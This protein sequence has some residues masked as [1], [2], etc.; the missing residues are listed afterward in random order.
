MAGTAYLDDQ[1]SDQWSEAYESVPVLAKEYPTREKFLQAAPDFAY[2][3][4][5][6]A[7]ES[8]A[9]GTRSEL[10]SDGITSFVSPFGCPD[11]KD[12][13]EATFEAAWD[14]V[15]DVAAI[16]GVPDRGAQLIDE[17][18]AALDKIEQTEAGKGLSVLWYDSG[19][20]TP[21]VGTG[22]GGPQLVL[23]AV[24]ATNVFADTKDKGWA[25][26]SW[27]KVL[28][29]DPDVIV[30]ADASWSTAKEK[31]KY[32][33]SDSV[34]SQLSAVKDKQF[35]TVPFA[36]STPGIRLVEGAQSVSDQFADLDA[37]ADK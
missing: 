16:F 31:Q 23:D 35:T 29:V 10:K 13:P 5:S 34:L 3:S 9:V 33:E 18:K 32:L 6:S 17:Q 22:G 24:G 37:S 15:E 36:A 11:E 7:F 19:D 12:R 14:E 21:F 1:V 30:L 26:G 25:D 27:E 28:E 2:A 4:Y 20:K 8:K